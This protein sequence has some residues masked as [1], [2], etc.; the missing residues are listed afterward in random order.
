M[1]SLPYDIEWS[2]GPYECAWNIICAS[3]VYETILWRIQQQ[4]SKV[5]V[6]CLKWVTL[7]RCDVR[8][9]PSTDQRTTSN[10]T[11]ASTGRSILWHR[12]H[13]ALDDISYRQWSATAAASFAGSECVHVLLV[14]IVNNS[15]CM[16][17]VRLTGGWDVCNWPNIF[18][19]SV[20]NPAVC[21]ILKHCG[22]TQ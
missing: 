19:F 1:G 3:V 14:E 13:I 16:G 2:L 15:Q 18:P 10:W 7:C 6:T 22:C 8:W 20:A 9:C 11:A 17:F 5:Y 12:Q 21:A 4:I